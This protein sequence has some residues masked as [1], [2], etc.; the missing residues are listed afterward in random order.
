M[1][2]ISAA[3][4]AMLRYLQRCCH[5]CKYCRHRSFYFVPR[6]SRMVSLSHHL[7]G[8]STCQQRDNMYDTR[9]PRYFSAPGARSKATPINS[10]CQERLFSLVYAKNAVDEQGIGS[11]RAVRHYK[12]RLSPASTTRLDASIFSMSFRVA[13]RRCA[14]RKSYIY[15]RHQSTVYY[16]ALPGA[17]LYVF[18]AHMFYRY[19]SSR[20][21]LSAT[22]VHFASL[23]EVI[24]RAPR[25]PPREALTRHCEQK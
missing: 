14:L 6:L 13:R 23:K 5:R 11:L 8:A 9:L 7:P 18:Q 17:G 2:D 16:R 10:W 3:H 24:N 15:H 22:S 21:G 20:R 19:W 1:N 4:G 25:P 12:V